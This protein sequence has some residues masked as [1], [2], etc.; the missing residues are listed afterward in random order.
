M[1]KKKAKSFGWMLLVSQYDYRQ[2][3]DTSWRK[4]IKLIAL[5]GAIM[6]SLF[7]KSSD[8]KDF[9]RAEIKN[10]HL[11]LWVGDITVMPI[12]S[13]TMARLVIRCNWLSM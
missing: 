4:L 2:K 12:Y 10:N 11:E 7:V 9:W 1:V 6:M 3:M 8:P 5:E 13:R